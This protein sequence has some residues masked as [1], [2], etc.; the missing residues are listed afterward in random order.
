MK[1]CQ[2]ETEQDLRAR[3]LER[4][5]VPALA[6]AVSKP[7]HSRDR[8]AARAAVRVMDAAAAGAVAAGAE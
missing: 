3:A 2:E 5:V 7:A 8:A 6:R 1:K 4:V